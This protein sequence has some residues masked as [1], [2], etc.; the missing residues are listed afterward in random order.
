MPNDRGDSYPFVCDPVNQTLVHRLIPDSTVG[1]QPSAFAILAGDS[2]VMQRYYLP[3]AI[4][5]RRAGG[6]ADG[7]GRIP[8]DVA[9]IFQELVLAHADLFPLATGVL[10]DCEVFSFV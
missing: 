3:E 4:E 8:H 10:Y 1:R 6:A 2:A 9:V 5:H 7:V